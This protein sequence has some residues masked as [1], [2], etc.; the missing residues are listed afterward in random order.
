MNQQND[1][2]LHL[3]NFEG[4]IDLLLSLVKD[5]KMDIMEVDVVTLASEYISI[6]NNLRDKNI[7]LAS[8]YL[9]M[10]AT[11]INLKAKALLESPEDQKEVESVKKDLLKQLVE[12]Q[13]FKDVAQKLRDKETERK[14]IYIKL[15]EDISGFQVKVDEAHLDGKSNPVNLIISLRKMFE[16]NNAKK[17]REATIEH[18]KM[19]PAERRLEIITLFM[20]KENITFDDIFSVPSMNHFVLTMLTVLDMARKQELKIEQD[21][22]FDKIIIKKGVIN[23]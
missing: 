19:T 5:K 11:L 20:E 23:D 22:Q 10:A 3:K 6:I 14:D 9:V 18:F 2:F 1:N 16:R 15:R 13:K 17:M 4:P 7:D 21:S 8:E 12:H